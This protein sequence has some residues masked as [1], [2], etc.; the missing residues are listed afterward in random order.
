MPYFLHD[1]CDRHAGKAGLKLLVPLK[2]E[3]HGEVLFL[4]A[5]V[6]YA[7]IPNLLKS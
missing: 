5:V 7:V 6:E 4:G 2:P 3:D 1:L